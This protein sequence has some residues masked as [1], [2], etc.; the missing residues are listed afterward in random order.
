MG[1][2]VDA[3]LKVL[4]VGNLRV[5]DAS[6][7]SDFP[8]LTLS[9]PTTDKGPL[10]IPTPLASHYQVAVYA[11]AEQAVDIILAERV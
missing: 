4:G 10:Q 6:I 1:K 8:D 11:I 5:V 9:N 3:S 7:V 2:V